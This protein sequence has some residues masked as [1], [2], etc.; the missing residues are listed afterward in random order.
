MGI[1]GLIH[2]WC[3]LAFLIEEH[4]LTLSRFV[5]LE[6]WNLS[7]LLRGL[8]LSAPHLYGV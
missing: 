1:R 7:G 5:I 3:A 6:L 8:H 2:G 4:I